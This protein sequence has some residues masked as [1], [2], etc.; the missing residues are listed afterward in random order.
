M[1][2]DT[3]VQFTVSGGTNK[4]TMKDCASMTREDAVRYFE[5]K[6]NCSDGR[7]DLFG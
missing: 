1:S 7:R 3:S 6:G 2:G 5:D 4:F